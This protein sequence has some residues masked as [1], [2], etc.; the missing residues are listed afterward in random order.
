MSFEYDMGF[1]VMFSDKKSDA[2]QLNQ[3]GFS[4]ENI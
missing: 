1:R 4:F 3:K 2:L